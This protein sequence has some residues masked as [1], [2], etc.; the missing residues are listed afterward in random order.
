MNVLMNIRVPDELKNQFQSKCR[1]NHTYMTTEL[2]RFMKKFTK[3]ESVKVTYQKLIEKSEPERWGN[4]I[5]D[6]NT[7]TWMT[8]EEYN[9]GNKSNVNR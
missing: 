2:I 4:L 5:K 7:Q 3:D 6:P 9:K 8:I 1:D